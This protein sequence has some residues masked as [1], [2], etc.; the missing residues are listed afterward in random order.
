MVAKA[1]EKATHIQGS[2]GISKYMYT[3]YDQYMGIGTT[4]SKIQL[5]IAQQDRFHSDLTVLKIQRQLSHLVTQQAAIGVVRVILQS[6]ILL[7]IIVAISM[8]SKRNGLPN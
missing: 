2:G 4:T 3:Y 6:L 8:P 7:V 1:W 5:P